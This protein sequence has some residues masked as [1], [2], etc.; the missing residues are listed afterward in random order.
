M[1]FILPL[2]LLLAV[3]TGIFFAFMGLS[4]IPAM[5]YVPQLVIVLAIIASVFF[6]IAGPN[7]LEADIA[8]IF[9]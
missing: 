2:F 9:R 5:K 4:D 6:G 7:A 8:A 1:N 3:I